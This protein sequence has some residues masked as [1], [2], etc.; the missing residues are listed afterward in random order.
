VIRVLVPLS[1][2]AVS[3]LV[4]AAG[5]S[6]WLS[7]RRGGAPDDDLPPTILS[8]LVPF[9]ALIVAVIVV[10]SLVVVLTG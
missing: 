8:I 9:V 2:L 4:I 10:T 6:L 5:V 1:V 7:D 3:L